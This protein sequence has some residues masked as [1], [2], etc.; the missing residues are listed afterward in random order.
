M[1]SFMERRVVLGQGDA[2]GIGKGDVNG[3]DKGDASE[4]YR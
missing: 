2:S 3:I 1:I 4:R